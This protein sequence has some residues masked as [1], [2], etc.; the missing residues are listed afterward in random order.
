MKEGQQESNIFCLAKAAQHNAELQWI[1][2][3][4]VWSNNKKDTSEE[5]IYE[6]L[7]QMY[8]SGEYHPEWGNSITKEHTCYTLTDKWMLTQKLGITKIQF[9]KHMKLKKKEDHSVDT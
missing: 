3:Q 8:G 4:E 2:T 9:A 5:W 1:C 6:I 7:R